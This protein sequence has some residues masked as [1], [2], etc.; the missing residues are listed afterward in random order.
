MKRARVVVVTVI[1]VVFAY[2]ATSYALGPSA[3]SDLPP[4]FDVA[5]LPATPPSSDDAIAINNLI[6][7]A[8]ADQQYGITSSSYAQARRVASTSAGDLYL[9]PGP[10]GACL[11]FAAGVSC[12]DLRSTP[13]LALLTIDTASGMAVGGG[14]ALSDI[15]RIVVTSG[16]SSVTAPVVSG[17]FRITAQDGVVPSAS[18]VYFKA[19]P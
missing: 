9:I 17:V 15:K 3:S 6:G 11:A 18:P 2:G 8:G 10:S 19:T 4:G 1:L 7:A 5:D 12:G 14:V 13:M 16:T